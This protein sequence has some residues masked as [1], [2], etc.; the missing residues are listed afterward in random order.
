MVTMLNLIG[1]WR[2]ELLLRVPHWMG[3]LP[4]DRHTDQ[5]HRATN[6]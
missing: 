3:R 6:G 2:L 1:S 4:V 5:G